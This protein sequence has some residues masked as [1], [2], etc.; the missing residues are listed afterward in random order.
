MKGFFLKTKF[1]AVLMIVA[2]LLFF[3]SITVA[4]FTCVFTELVYDALTPCKKKKIKTS[5][6]L[7]LLCFVHFKCYCFCL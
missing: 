7:F 4:L 6:N 2:H 3:S 1:I 5:C